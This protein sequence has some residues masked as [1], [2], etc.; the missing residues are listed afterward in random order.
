MR[1]M[2]FAL[3]ESGEIKK[4]SVPVKSMDQK[5][6]RA[7]AEEARD[8]AHRERGG[9]ERGAVDDQLG[10]EEHRG[11]HEGRQPVMAHALTG[12]GRGDRNGAVH[13]ERRGDPQQAGGNNAEDAPGLAL[14]PAEKAVNAV[15]EED[16]DEGADGNAQDPVPENLPELE[17]EIIPE[18]DK[19]PAEN[20]K[21][22]THNLKY[23]RKN[24]VWEEQICFSCFLCYGR[25]C[26][27]IY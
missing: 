14:H 2:T 6:C 25:G 7:A 8:D 3:R 18:I 12:K 5:A 1:V 4:I 17:I 23:S 13:A 16:G 10:V 24:G 22:I 20:V 11:H 9:P 26:D 19:L 27:K 15:L 21:Q